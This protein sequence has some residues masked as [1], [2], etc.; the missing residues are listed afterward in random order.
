MTPPQA[1]IRPQ[2]SLLQSVSAAV[3][4]RMPRAKYRLMNLLANPAA[5]PFIA[6]SAPE[7]G[8]CRFVCH[9]ADSVAREA[10]YTG[11]YEPQETALFNSVLKPGMTFLDLGAN[12]GYFSLLAATRVGPTGRVHSF[13]P[14]PRIL[15]LLRQNVA[16]NQF[17]N[18]TIHPVAASDGPGELRFTGFSETGGNWGISTLAGDGTN[19]FT[20]ATVA[21]DPYLDQQGVD[22]VDFVKMDIEGAEDLAL[23]GMDAG[24]RRGRYRQLMIELHPGRLAERGRNARDLIDLLLQAGYTA[25]TIR[26]DAAFTRQAAYQRH[27]TA[28]DVLAPY[29]PAADLTDWPHLFFTWPGV[30]AA[31]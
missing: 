22:Q 25:Q 1:P 17:Q 8:A 4:R 9:L 11:R 28:T 18:V 10:F 6:Q 15:A 3:V 7:A 27:L 19:A 12:W 5:G 29:D 26:H 24:L 30:E 2:P 13:E 16:L 23:A 14:D 21:V 20:A 31:R